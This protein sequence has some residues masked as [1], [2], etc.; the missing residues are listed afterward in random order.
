MSAGSIKTHQLQQPD[1]VKRGTA[2]REAALFILPAI[3]ITVISILVFSLLTGFT[4]EQHNRFV[5]IIFL[6]IIPSLLGTAGFQVI[7]YR[8]IEEKHEAQ[9]KAV[10]RALFIGIIFGLSFSAA[11]SGLTLPFIGLLGLTLTDFSYF[12][13][14]LMLFTM[15]WIFMAVF[16]ATRQFYYPV[17]LIGFGFSSILAITYGFHRID[18]V[19][20][21]Y[22]YTLG[23]ILLF[24][25]I[26]VALLKAFGRIR[27]DKSSLPTTSLPSLVTH[28]ISLI[29]FS[30]LYLLATFLDKIIVW[31]YQGTQSGSGLLIPGP[32]TIGAFLGLIPLFSVVAT[33]YFGQVSRQIVEKRYEGTLTEIK[34]RAAKYLKMYRH[35][36]GYMVAIWAV[37]FI[38]T[39]GVVYFLLWDPLVFRTTITIAVGSLFLLLILHNSQLLVTFGEG[40]ISAFAAS[41]IIASE[42]ASILFI[43]ID[44]WFAA[45]GFLTGAILGF[46]LSEVYTLILSSDFEF[47][48][49]HYAARSAGVRWE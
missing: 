16:W 13:V 47:K 21:I 44:V 49:Y 43:H 19:Y 33:L 10:D 46:L 18:P 7:I 15:I 34:K 40:R 45:A 28:N 32:Y 11:V 27:V 26:A 14:L 41:F 4:P 6:A 12:V 48:I 17:V 1:T 38:L 2:V 35:T 25:M 37:L 8:I 31:V 30:I 5:V 23:V 42:L 20:T 29:F 22:G 24:I 3:I 39:T 36:L 9:D